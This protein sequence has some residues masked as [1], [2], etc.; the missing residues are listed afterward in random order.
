MRKNKFKKVLVVLG[1]TSGERAISLQSG[2][3]CIQALK[4]KGYSGALDY[5][6]Q[7][8]GEDDRYDDERKGRLKENYRRQTGYR[9]PANWKTNANHL[10]GQKGNNLTKGRNMVYLLKYLISRS[11]LAK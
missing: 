10:V 3:A 4:R 11:G 6:L 2:K 5:R 7:K 1:G 9:K 8:G